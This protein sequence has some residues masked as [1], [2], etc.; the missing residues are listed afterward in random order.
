MKKIVLLFGIHLWVCT[1]FSHVV[2]SDEKERPYGCKYY[3]NNR[4]DIPEH[5]KYI[6]EKY[7][8]SSVIKCDNTYEN[9]Q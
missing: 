1:G 2:I 9:L 8:G 7:P 3:S 5:M 4:D 6:I